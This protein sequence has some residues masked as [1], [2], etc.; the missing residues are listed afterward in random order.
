MK[1][2]ISKN[3]YKI[4]QII[5]NFTGEYNED[6]EQEVYIRTYKNLEKY[7]EQNKFTQWICTITANLCRDYLKSSY[8]KNKKMMDTDEDNLNNISSKTTPEAIYT[9]KERQKIVI[10]AVNLLPKKM[11][12]AVILYEFEDYSYEK[13]AEK[14]HIPIGT[15]KSRINSARKILSEE[16]KFLI[17]EDYQW[18]KK[19]FTL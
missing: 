15:V 10:R 6:L 4:R 12:E 18:R 17:E 16:L 8:F 5:K 2:I 9:A 3:G 19:Y 7:K 11:K 14:L 13:I 1:D